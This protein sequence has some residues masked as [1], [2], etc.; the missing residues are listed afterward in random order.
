M[1]S[2]W[3][4]RMCMTTLLLLLTWGTAYAQEDVVA[5]DAGGADVSVEPDVGELDAG[6]APEDVAAE[7]MATGD[8]AADAGSPDEDL[9]VCVPACDGKVCGPDGCGNS[10]GECADGS[11]CKDG[12]CE[13]VVCGQDT[14]CNGCCGNYAEGA[15]CQCDAECGNFGDCCDDYAEFCDDVVPTECG[16]GTC[17][18]C[19]GFYNEAASCQCDDQCVTYGDCC[20]DACDLCGYC[21]D[22]GNQ[23]QCPDWLSYEGCCSPDGAEI[24][25]CN[26]NQHMTNACDAGTVCGW[27]ATNGYYNCVAQAETD[28]TG[29]NP[30]SC[31][32]LENPSTGGDEDAAG[33]GDTATGGGDDDAS[34]GGNGGNGTS[35]STGGAGGDVTAGGGNNGGAGANPEKSSS[36]CTAAPDSTNS[37][38]WT[39]LALA[40]LFAGIVRRRF[41][42]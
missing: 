17:A 30:Y 32:E 14:T 29:I 7:D 33:T 42:N 10:C 23:G 13:Q 16:Q 2:N 27:D 4:S 41:A 3:V 6:P 15:P 35:D 36:G 8:V 18:D 25:Y 28:P 1:F 24:S 40:G 5:S 26:E 22:G 19:C 39:L 11:T 34:G 20:D 21:D 9:V 38:G 12:A 37:I 31:E